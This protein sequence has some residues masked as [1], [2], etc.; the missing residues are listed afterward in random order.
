VP[1]YDFLVRPP[2][3][4]WLRSLRLGGCLVPSYDFLVR[5]PAGHWLRSLR[6]GGCCV[7]SYDFL[8]VPDSAARLGTGEVVEV[9]RLFRVSSY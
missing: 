8:H 1:S 9:K 7:P 3:G 2:A 5:P 4:H 6:L